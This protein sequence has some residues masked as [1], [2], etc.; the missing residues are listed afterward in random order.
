MSENLE[1]AQKLVSDVQVRRHDFYEHI[2][3]AAALAL[4]DIAQSLQK[5]AGP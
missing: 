2:H 5:R 1:L 3:M 4:I